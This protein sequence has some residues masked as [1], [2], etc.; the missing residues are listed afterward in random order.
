MIENIFGKH[1]GMKVY[2]LSP[3]MAELMRLFPMDINEGAKYGRPN[4]NWRYLIIVEMEHEMTCTRW[5]YNLTEAYVFAKEMP[6]GKV[7]IQSFHSKI[8]N[9]LK[10]KR[11]YKYFYN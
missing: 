5:A 7:T 4:I 10:E 9:E 2:R 3:F 1:E 8:M 11:K 6:K